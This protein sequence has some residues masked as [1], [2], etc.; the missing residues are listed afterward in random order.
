MLNV[1]WTGVRR[2][3]R[4][5][6]TMEME[7]AMPAHGS[8]RS[9]FYFEALQRAQRD[10]AHLAIPGVEVEKVSADG[11]PC[12]W[13]RAET[14]NPNHVVLYLHGG[15]YVSCSLLTHRQMMS[16]MSTTSKVA[17]LGVDYRLAPL[18]PFPCA[19]E[20]ALKAYEWLLDQGYLAENIVFAGDSAGGGLVFATLL[21][22]KQENQIRT[23]PIP[24]PAATVTFSPWTDLSI[25]GKSIAV[26]YETDK[27]FNPLRIKITGFT[28]Y[29]QYR[30][31]RFQ[32]RLF[33]RMYVQWP[34]RLSNP[35]ASPLFGDHR[36]MPPAMIHCSAEE[37]LMDD[38]LR[39]EAKLR[40]VGVRVKLKVWKGT[41][42]VF[43][44]LMPSSEQTTDCFALVAEFINQLLT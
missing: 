6:T 14:S 33:A 11:V 1:D 21:L 42:H 25:T 28:S 7:D 43:P 20:D 10:A 15:G 30:Y 18:H 2:R 40:E 5:R 13:L 37:M 24:M 22:I 12:E 26:N 34:K 32:W 19:V 8:M 4:V 16:R 35:M 29:F 27:L 41:T 17:V 3:G 44:I 9:A 36:G 23:Q 31:I 38:S 39:M